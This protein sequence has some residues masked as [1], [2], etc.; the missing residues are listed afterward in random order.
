MPRSFFVGFFLLWLKGSGSIQK[1]KEGRTAMKIYDPKKI[2]VPVDFSD[3]GALALEHARLFSSL[4]EAHHSLIEDYRN[5]FERTV[6]HPAPW[7]PRE[8]PPPPARMK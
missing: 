3:L 5:T 7:V 1:P 2:L 4:R 6:Y 8:I